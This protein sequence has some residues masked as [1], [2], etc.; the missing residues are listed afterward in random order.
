MVIKMAVV[1]TIDEYILNKITSLEEE[2][3]QLEKL[4]KELQDKL[5]N[6]KIEVQS[7][8]QD[9]LA[10]LEESEKIVPTNYKYYLLEVADTYDFKQMSPDILNHD[11]LLKCL[12]DDKELE[13]FAKNQYQK[14]SNWQSIV[15]VQERLY[16]YQIN[17]F[18]QI[19][20]IYIYKSY[21]GKVEVTASAIRAN[22]N[23]FFDYDEAYKEGL[24]RLRKSIKEY[25][26]KVNATKKR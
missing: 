3:K 11:V 2:K 19:V 26:D 1:K 5:E 10:E 9:D 6:I 4:T 20:A 14:Y 13:K 22:E 24:A 23:K 16:N 21:V 12:S 7:D 18:G 25:L 17:F 8:E 15:D